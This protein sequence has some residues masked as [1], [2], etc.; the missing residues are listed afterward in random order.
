MTFK[1]DWEKTNSRVQIPDDTI[2][3]MV[4]QA[5]PNFSLSSFDIIKGGCANLNI[6]LEF[7]DQPPAIL[8]IY[9]RDRDAAYREQKLSQ[10]IGHDVPIPKV[11]YVGDFQEYRFAITDFLP[12]ITLRE[13]LLDHQRDYH[14]GDI[15]RLM[16]AAGRMLGIF[17]TFSF[18][19]AGFFNQNL[20]VASPFGRTDLT[21]YM[22]E[23]LAHP[24][25]IGELGQDIITQLRHLLDIHGDLLPDDTWHTLVHADY[26]PAN[27]LVDKATGRW[28]IS[29]I[30]DWEFAFSG[31]WLCDVANMLRYAHHMPSVYEESFIKGISDAGLILPNQ[32]RIS[33][34]MLNILSLIDCLKHCPPKE[35]PNQCKDICELIR[36]FVASLEMQ[37]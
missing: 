25:V 30:L 11:L 4:S 20:V 16:E 31:P 37:R 12:G 26:D 35:R 36:Y 8:R 34:T 1:N 13:L 15:Q 21:L 9:V 24:T 27:I 19:Q 6:R 14:D 3:A 29:G 33:V 2:C 17:H 10:I 32:W 28:E 18:S 5:I 23:C 22:K 7:K